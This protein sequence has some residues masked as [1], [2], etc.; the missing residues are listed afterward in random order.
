MFLG[1]FIENKGPLRLVKT[2]E[3]I[4]EHWSEVMVGKQNKK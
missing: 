4:G 1:H 2:A 3:G